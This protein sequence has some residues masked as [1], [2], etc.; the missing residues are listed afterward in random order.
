M[1][2]FLC[3]SIFAVDQVTELVG[4]VLFSRLLISDT[5]KHVQMH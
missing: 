5:Y 3:V 2:T 1:E 4:T